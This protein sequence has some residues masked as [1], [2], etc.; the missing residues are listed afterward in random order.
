MEAGLPT[1]RQPLHRNK[2]MNMVK[3]GTWN[4]RTMLQA[5]VMNCLAD[6]IKR[7]E[8][9]VVDLQEVRWKGK[10]EIRKPN[11]TLYLFRE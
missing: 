4:V 8:I 3:F 9:D 11:F 2:D 7:Y 5:G 10:G 6:E 1:R